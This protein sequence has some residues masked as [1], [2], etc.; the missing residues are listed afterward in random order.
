MAKHTGQPIDKIKFDTER[1]YFLSA[2]ESKAHGL[3][4]EVLVKKKDT[5]AKK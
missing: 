2:D 4:D 5:E 1:D 3:I